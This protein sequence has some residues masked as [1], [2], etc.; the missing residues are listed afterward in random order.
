MRLFSA[1]LLLSTLFAATTIAAER[2]I[3][4][5]RSFF[6]SAKVAFESHAEAKPFGSWLQLTLNVKYAKPIFDG[7]NKLY[8]GALK[9]RGEAHI[10]V[11]T[12]PEFD[13]TL[14]KKLTMK[15]IEAIAK[16]HHIQR[17]QFSLKCVGRARTV[18]KGSTRADSVYFLV[19]KSND[20]R[21][22]RW[23]VWRAYVKKGGDPSTFNPDAF[24]P[25]VTLGF[26]TRDMF[27]EDGI[28][29]GYNTCWK[30]LKAV[31]Y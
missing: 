4:I 29:K 24:W 14:S 7:I 22:I 13:Q 15:E 6:N 18:L 19:A 20:L 10:T 8:K 30:Q 1:T 25:H 9:T 28:Y 26:T 12:P 3:P 5:S 31:K 16:K 17:A 21:N 23:A 2:P 27:P 11:I